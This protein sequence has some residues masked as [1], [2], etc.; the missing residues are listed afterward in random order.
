MPIQFRCPACNRMLGIARRKAG[1]EVKCPRC[2][3]QIRVPALAGV[4][5]EPVGA[6]NG[7][8]VPVVPVVQPLPPPKPPQ[9]PPELEALPLFE[10]PDFEALL[11]PAVQK[12]KPRPRKAAK[13][14]AEEPPAPPP[15][16]EPP[17]RE[18]PR[19]ASAAE[20]DVVP[21]VVVTRKN[22]TLVAVLI[23]VL[24]GLAFAAGYF[25]AALTVSPKKPAATGFPTSAGEK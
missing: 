13:S 18:K 12:P 24:I 20:V 2:T 4:A 17:P 21:A 23:A 9:P 8:T 14:V 6:A 7:R 15:V 5:V 10:R 25:L 19:P 1:T 22:L 16:I 3:A 11:S